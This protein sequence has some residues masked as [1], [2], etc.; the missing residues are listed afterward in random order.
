MERCVVHCTDD[1]EEDW[2]GIYDEQLA[3][4]WSPRSSVVRDSQQ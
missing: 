4:L 3:K 1:E 2:Y